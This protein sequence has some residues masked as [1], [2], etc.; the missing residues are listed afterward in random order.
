MGEI[1]HL[2]EIKRPDGKDKGLLQPTDWNAPHDIHESGG[3]HLTVG[4]IPDG[5]FLKRSGTE[6][7]GVTPPSGGGGGD[8][9]EHTDATGAAVHGLGSISTQSSG[10]VSITGGTLRNVSIE[11]STIDGGIY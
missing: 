6:I 5:K 4:A 9:S 2:K 10:N 7:I 3:A 11:E 8:I 1:T